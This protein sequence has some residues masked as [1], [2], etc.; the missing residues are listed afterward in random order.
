MLNNFLK[1]Y[2]AFISEDYLPD[3][4]YFWI[5][6]NFRTIL[7][8]IKKD[9]FG[10]KFR[11]NATFN[12]DNIRGINDKKCQN[13]VQKLFNF[14]SSNENLYSISNSFY[15][16]HLNKYQSKKIFKLL[17]ESQL[18]VQ[19]SES[20]SGYENPIHADTK[21]R[22]VHGLIYFDTHLFSGGEL[23]LWIPKKN[24]EKYLNQIPFMTDLDSSIKIQ[25][26]SNLGAIILSTPYSYHKGCKTLGCR[27]FI[28]FSFNHPK[29]SLWKKNKSYRKPFNLNF[30][31]GL[32]KQKNPFLFRL[33]RPVFFIKNI[34]N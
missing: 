25:P 28:Y 8:S 2:P 7:N 3:E 6:V 30:T 17:K 18:E 20:S 10:Q 33:M 31:Q 13:G 4:I 23:E 9:S 32:L 21:N 19:F 14:L 22:L 29:I 11:L 12:K 34:V 26:K 16:E 15:R 24:S 27:K 1:K 5:N